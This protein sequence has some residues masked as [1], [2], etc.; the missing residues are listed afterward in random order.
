MA[1]EPMNEGVA[2]EHS[3]EEFKFADELEALGKSIGSFV[4]RAINSKQR[5]EVE[6]EV[7]DGMRR[8]ADEMDKVASSVREGTFQEQVKENV[9]KIRE[10]IETGKVREDMRKG[11]VE[12]LRSIRDTL[13]KMAESLDEKPQD[14]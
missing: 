7:R 14:K 13:N 1:D 4:D 12:A 10:D 2:E 8:F 9:D 11:T 3:H 5:H 6:Q